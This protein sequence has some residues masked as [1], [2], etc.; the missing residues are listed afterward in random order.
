MK[1]SPTFAPMTADGSLPGAWKEWFGLVASRTQIHSVSLT[2]SSIAASDTN[3]E[4]ITAPCV[5]G[6]HVEINPPGYVD[7]FVLG[8]ARVAAK[9]TVK[10]A[11]GNVKSSAITPPAGTYRI[12]VTRP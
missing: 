9:N 8:G 4:T 5:E 11:F 10:A 6:D 3:E 2:P 7:G 12:K 1:P